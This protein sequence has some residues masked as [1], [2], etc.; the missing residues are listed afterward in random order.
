MRRACSHWGSR[1]ARLT[2]T[3]R[4]RFAIR[5]PVLTRALARHPG[6]LAEGSSPVVL[7]VL[8][9]MFQGR[10]GCGVLP[11]YFVVVVNAQ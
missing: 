9:L 11:R 6:M 8:R 1:L 5:L 7:E 4:F 10:G 3:A 2:A